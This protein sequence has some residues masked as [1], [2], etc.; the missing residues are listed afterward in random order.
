LQAQVKVRLFVEAIFPVALHLV[1]VQIA[2]YLVA[3][4]T[5]LVAL[6]PATKATLLIALRPATKATLLIALHLVASLAHLGKRLQVL[7]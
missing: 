6:C 2:L 7:I 4:A 5:L 3:K 1:K